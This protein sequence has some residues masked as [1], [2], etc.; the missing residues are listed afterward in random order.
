MVTGHM[1]CHLGNG[2]AECL[3]SKNTIEPKA[4]N[5]PSRVFIKHPRE[6]LGRGCLAQA[7]E[8]PGSVCAAMRGRKPLDAQDCHQHADE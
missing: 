4:L 1:K 3:G 8:S 5:A 2:T 7:K 6:D